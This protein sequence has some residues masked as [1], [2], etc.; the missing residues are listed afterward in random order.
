MNYEL[1]PFLHPTEPE[2]FCVPL[3]RHSNG[4]CRL[5]ISSTEARFYTTEQ[6]PDFVKAQLAM[7][8]AIPPKFPL[9]MDADVYDVGLS[10]HRVNTDMPEMGWRLSASYFV[11]VVAKKE[12]EVLAKGV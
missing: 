12:L 2:L 7:I 3:K 4:D 11:I 1:D 10:A 6:L 9:R 8:C 5:Y